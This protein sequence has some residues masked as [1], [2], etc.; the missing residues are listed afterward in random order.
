MQFTKMHGL[1]N[2]F[3]IV[4]S[5]QVPEHV[6]DLAK[7]IC[8]RRTGVGA[9][10]LVYIL[11]S[12]KACFQMRIFNSDGTE[13]QQCGNA[14]R[15]VAKYYY[16]RMDSSSSEITVET[17]IGVQSVWLE[18]M[19]RVVNS[20]KVDMGAP[21]LVAEQVPMIAKQE[22]AIE[23]EI[24]VEGQ[25]FSLTAV[26]MGNPHA[27]IEVPD[28][29]EFDVTRWGPKLETHPAFPEKVNVE[30]VTFSSSSEIQ[31]RVWERGAGETQACGS[32]A[33]AVLVAGVLQNKVA[34]KATVH[35]LGGDLLIEWDEQNNH[36]Y[37]TGPAANV[38]KGQWLE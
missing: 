15:C 11:P 22:K 21:I 33:C 9:D 4:Q 36:V 7:K 19:D 8:H 34:R 29:G 28:P 26:S 20:I 17:Q 6:A 18:V 1:G 31:M 24:E 27:V 23:E 30:F 5:R 25:S 3:V 2:D 37:M 32:G 16:E 12:S 38:Y 14:L 13:S 10:G 35:L